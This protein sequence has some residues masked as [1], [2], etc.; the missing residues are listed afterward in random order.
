MVDILAFGKE[1]MAKIGMKFVSVPVL[2][3]PYLDKTFY[4]K[5][6][7]G[8]SIED[9]KVKLAKFDP[10]IIFDQTGKYAKDPIRGFADKLPKDWKSP[11]AIFVRIVQDLDSDTWSKIMANIFEP[12]NMNFTFTWDFEYYKTPQVDVYNKKASNTKLNQLTYDERER[13]EHAKAHTAN[14]ISFKRR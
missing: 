8:S 6:L 1:E 13:M 9:L 11:N 5:T 7:W 4:M 10:I 2:S 12:E 3:I 14:K